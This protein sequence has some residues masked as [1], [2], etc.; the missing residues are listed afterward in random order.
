MV[1]TTKNVNSGIFYEVRTLAAVLTFY[2][3]SYPGDE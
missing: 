2:K 1:A 3:V